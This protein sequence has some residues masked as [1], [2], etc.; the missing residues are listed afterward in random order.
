L[1]LNPAGPAVTVF[2]DAA[3]DILTGSSGQDWFI[4][5]AAGPGT[6]DKATDLIVGE[7]FTDLDIAFIQGL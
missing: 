4:F 3:A 6:R 7:S 5:N 2:D 1:F